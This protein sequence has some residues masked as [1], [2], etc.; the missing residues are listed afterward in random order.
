MSQTELVLGVEQD[1]VKVIESVS[2]EEFSSNRRLRS[3]TK[4]VAEFLAKIAAV[5][6]DLAKQSTGEISLKSGKR[7]NG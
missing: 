7:R 3:K 6:R 2:L 4:K 1:F 5:Q